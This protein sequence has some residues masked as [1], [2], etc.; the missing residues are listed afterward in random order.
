MKHHTIAGAGGLQLHVVETGNPHGRPILFVHGI[1]QCWLSWQ[2]QLNSELAAHYRLVAI[3]L[4]G[5]GLSEKP[6]DAYAD[7][8]LWADDLDAVLRALAL[9]GTV[10]CG[11]SYGP[12]VILDY[13]RHHGA[14]R[15][16]GIVYVGGITKLGTDE[17][18]SVIRPEFFSIVPSFFS[19]DVEE[20]TGGLRAL[21]RRCFMS[22]LQPEELYL[23]LGYNV[24]VPPHVRQA[25]LSRVID[26]DDVMPKLRR[27][28]VLIVQGDQDA[29]V[30][31]E[32]VAQHTAVLPHA[33]VALM[34]GAGHAPFWDRAAEFNER[35]RTFC[36]RLEVQAV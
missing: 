25:L 32:A 5:H 28:P 17:A 12:L 13:V 35:V 22:D 33:E 19:T 11:W 10:V 26:N 27:T 1:S 7:T 23:M 14:E 16:G 29:N 30:K 3:D 2:R 8:R 4:R 36:E 31:P 18:N 9:E 15:L 6:R 34:P 20:S 21:L 24:S